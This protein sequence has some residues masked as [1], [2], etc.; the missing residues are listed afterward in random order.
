[1][2]DM[3]ETKEGS[4]TIQVKKATARKLQSLAQWGDSYDAVINRLLNGKKPVGKV[5]P[6]GD[7]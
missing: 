2:V 7:G 1:M 5:E 6:P 4:T 3:K